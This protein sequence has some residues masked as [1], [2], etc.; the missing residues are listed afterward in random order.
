MACSLSHPFSF[1]GRPSGVSFAF[2]LIGEQNFAIRR[3]GP[4]AISASL[5]T[6]TMGLNLRGKPLGGMENEVFKRFSFF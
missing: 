5:H 4:S 1:L 6:K 3:Q 2:H